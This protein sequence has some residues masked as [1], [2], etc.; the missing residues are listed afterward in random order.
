MSETLYNDVFVSYSRKNKEFAQK[1]V[2]AIYD[3]GHQNV[4][5]DWEDIEYAE[6][7]WEKI[8]AGI[9][10]ADN[11]VFVLTPDSALSEVC[12]DEVD[13]A[14]KSGKRIIPVLHQEITDEAVMAKMHPVISTHNWLPFRDEDNFDATLK[15]LLKTIATDLDY[16]RSHT[17]LLTRAQEWI[18]SGRDRGY[19]LSVEET[20]NAEIWFA[21]SSGKNPAP[22]D[23]QTQFILESRKKHRASSRRLLTAAGFA[24]ILSLTLAVFAVFQSMEANEQRTLAVTSAEIAEQQ[25]DIANTAQFDAELQADIASTAQYDAEIQAEVANTAQAIAVE[26]ADVASTAQSVAEVQANLAATSEYEALNLA[27]E[28]L[29]LSLA[30]NAQNVYDSTNNELGLLLALEANNMDDP[31]LVS[32]SALARVAYSPGIINHLEFFES[33]VID[34]VWL[35]EDR[36]EVA[37]IDASG[38]FMI[39]DPFQNNLKT[40]VS[41]DILPVA[42]SVDGDASHIAIVGEDD[43]LILDSRKGDVIQQHELDGLFWID[44]DFSDDGDFIVALGDSGG[45]Y[46]FDTTSGDIIDSTTLDLDSTSAVEFSPDGEQIAVS[47]Y[48]SEI[49][50]YERDGFAFSSEVRVPPSTAPIVVMDWQDNDLITATESGR[51]IIWNSDSDFVPI[52]SEKVHD[53]AIT[54]L[55]YVEQDQS[56]IIISGSVDR[57]VRVIER[58]TGTTNYV[59]RGHSDNVTAVHYVADRNI[60]FSASFDEQIYMWDLR[61]PFTSVSFLTDIGGHALDL[62]Y[63]END[64]FIVT[65]TSSPYIGEVSFT[66]SDYTD[67]SAIEVQWYDTMNEDNEIEAAE[68]LRVVSKED[69]A[70]TLQLSGNIAIWDTNKRELEDIIEFDTE[71][72]WFDVSNKDHNELVIVTFDGEI[73]LWDVEDKETVWSTDEFENSFINDIAFIEELKQ[74]VFNDEGTLVFIDSE[75]GDKLAEIELEGEEFV[76]DIEVRK[77]GAE[78]L[79]GLG[80]GS[81]QIVDT[82][83]MTITSVLAGHESEVAAVAYLDDRDDRAVSVS[84]DRKI[85]LWDLTEQTT[86]RIFEEH[87]NAGLTVDSSPNSQYILSADSSG[88]VLLWEVDTLEERIEWVCLNRF[89]RDFTTLERQAYQLESDNINICDTLGYTVANGQEDR[90]QERDDDDDDMPEASPTFDVPDTPTMNPTIDPTLPSTPDGSDRRD[91]QNSTQTPN[92]QNER[93]QQSTPT[94]QNNQNER[95]T[96]DNS[97]NGNNSQP[98]QQGTPSRQGNNN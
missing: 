37:T 43:V 49:I 62:H 39:I 17:R 34:M 48:S 77:D 60:L 52:L 94:T 58:T 40:D 86:I 68:Q 32:Q 22:T 70:Y 36:N 54:S 63:L 4:W 91:E 78:L 57:T 10:S 87:T 83:T 29:S 71:L 47:T 79:V 27:A 90:K 76:L 53:N 69:L 98:N 67:T 51:I 30:A 8:K 6:D 19:L 33:D 3:N 82:A 81:I 25:A 66:S 15:T 92:T 11:F 88:E 80:D 50:I 97:S 21:Q 42:M 23:L 44:V 95:N 20:E 45:L 31:P 18:A 73:F 59:L 16:V 28:G 35:G 65:I 9:E 2:K 46:L 74:I 14:A 64:S 72:L 5:I 24:V 85:I 84:G 96:Q 89:I 12:Y 26:Q 38:T 41:F 75:T 7:W 61:S 55:Q 56:S 1:L 13:H 93:N